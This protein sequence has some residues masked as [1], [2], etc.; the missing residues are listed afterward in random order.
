MITEDYV[1]LETA[2][3]LKDKRFEFVTNRY[4]NAQYD[5]IRTVSDTFMLNWN[6]AKYMKHL[7]MEGAVA[8][9][10]LQMV[11]K[12]LD[13]KGL[14][15]SAVPFDIMRRASDKIVRFTAN[16]FVRH[17]DYLDNLTIGVFDSRQEATNAAIL[18]VLNSLE[19]LSIY[20]SQTP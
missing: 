2:R 6:D 8:I 7:G 1:S 17:P 12:C 10:T 16:V 14:Y 18:Y 19:S 3:L 4:Y 11:V 13:E 15:I 5:V 20:S 9:P